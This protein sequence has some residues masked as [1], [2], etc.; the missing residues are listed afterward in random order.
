M[1]VE[2]AFANPADNGEQGKAKVHPIARAERLSRCCW[3]SDREVPRGD[4]QTKEGGE[5]R[6]CGSQHDPPGGRRVVAGRRGLEIKDRLAEDAGRESHARQGDPA[7]R[8]G[9]RVEWSSKLR[10]TI[11]GARF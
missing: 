1:F 7:K 3:I 10:H 11:K 9:N 6:D 4:Q 5:E 2:L 8:P